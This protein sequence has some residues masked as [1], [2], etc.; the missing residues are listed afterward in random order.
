M[1]TRGAYRHAGRR[2]CEYVDDVA[3]FSRDGSI[4]PRVVMWR[5]GRTFRVDEA[6][7]RGRFRGPGRSAETV[8]YPVRICRVR[9][10]VY[11]ER[12]AARPGISMSERLLW[13]VSARDRVKPGARPW[14]GD[15]PINDNQG[16]FHPRRGICSR[17]ALTR[18]AY[19]VEDFSCRQPRAAGHGGRCCARAAPLLAPRPRLSRG[20]ASAGL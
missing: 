9:T 2:H 12:R 16:R 15:S 14:Q 10:S 1:V 5:D 20:T 13:W 3:T 7:G 4:T 8:R 18:A 17:H 11:L 6:A 19:L